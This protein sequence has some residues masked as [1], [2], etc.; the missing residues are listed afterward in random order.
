M[1]CPLRTI[2]AAIDDECVGAHCAWWGD[3]ACLVAYA[4]KA[5]K[6]SITPQ[7][8]PAGYCP[9]IPAQALREVI[10]AIL[11]WAANSDLNRPLQAA[12]PNEYARGLRHAAIEFEKLLK[13]E[14]PDE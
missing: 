3:D 14:A 1:I 6:L 10:D 7:V 2:N 5:V 13:R 9:V 11:D 12:G 4:G 8:F